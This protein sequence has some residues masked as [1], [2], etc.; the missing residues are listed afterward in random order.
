MRSKIAILTIATVSL[1]LAA[2]SEKE[3]PSTDHSEDNIIGTAMSAVSSNTSESGSDQAKIAMYDP[4]VCRIHQFDMNTSKWE[5]T[6]TP[7]VMHGNHKVMFEPNG[8]FV[9]DVVDQRL[10]VFDQQG[11]RQDPNVNFVGA[12]K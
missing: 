8:N 6:L 7:A 3:K 4:V 12:P 11:R 9:I 2:C 10:S 1:L 5:R